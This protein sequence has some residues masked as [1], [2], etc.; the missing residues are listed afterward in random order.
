[1]GRQLNE[2][3]WLPLGSRSYKQTKQSTAL[4]LLIMNPAALLDF[5]KDMHALLG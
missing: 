2:L 5:L 1:M 4:L 3:K